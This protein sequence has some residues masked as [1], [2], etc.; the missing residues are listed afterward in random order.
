MLLHFLF[1]FVGGVVAVASIAAFAWFRLGKEPG[2]DVS[3][4][5]TWTLG[6]MDYVVVGKDEPPSTTW[7]MRCLYDGNTRYM[8]DSA[9]LGGLWTRKAGS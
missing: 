2:G 4:G 1:G 8:H 9:R 5:Q 3:A 7:V 6:D